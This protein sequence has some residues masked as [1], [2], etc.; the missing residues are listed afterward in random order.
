MPKRPPA[1]GREPDDRR[2]RRTTRALTHALVALVLEKRY[3]RITI[4]DLLD[5]AAVGR[6]TFYAHY[7]GKDD[8][9]L[10]SFEALL[11][12]LDAGMKAEPAPRVAPVRELFRHA[13]ESRSFHRALA[14]AHMIDR[15]YQ[16]GTRQVA[17][18]IERRLAD[19]APAG[20]VPCDIRARALAGAMFGLLR[21]WLDDAPAYSPD[22]VD[23]MFHA[24]LVPAG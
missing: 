14:R 7:R 2:V 16:V 15:L 11:R 8:L 17:R 9:L 5:Q 19:V 10:R 23:E 3:D 6:S 4:Q 12:R 22:E 20:P 1:P 18:T 13:A 24:L 21:W